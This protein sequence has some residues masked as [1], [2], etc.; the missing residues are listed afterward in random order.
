MHSAVA[1]LAAGTVQGAMCAH[2]PAF[3]FQGIPFAEPPI[4]QLRFMPP[5]LFNGSYDGGSL[6]ATNPSHPCI[7]W[8]PSGFAVDDPT[9]SE[10]W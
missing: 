10:D 7:Q 9:P 1:D 2:A 8:S 3:S 6:D 5:K 4:D